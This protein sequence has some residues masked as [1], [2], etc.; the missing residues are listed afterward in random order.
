[1]D[2]RALLEAWRG[3]DAEAGRQLIT[4]YY[5]AIYRFFYGK[6]EAA[7]CEDLA[8][9][10]FEVVVRRRDAFR[11]DSPFRAYVYGIARFVLVAHIRRRQRHGKRF[12]PAEDSAIDP[13]TEGSVTA[14]FADR[15]LE[16]IVVQALRSLPLD[17]QILVEL[18]DWEG[19]TQ[20]E[21]AALFEA[22]QPTVARRLQRARTRLREAVERLVADPALRDASVHGLDS[23]MQ[24][25]YGKL[26]AHLGRVRAPEQ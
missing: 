14:L 5:A 12:E 20:A 11:G 22:P 10:T 18:K 7:A 1:M 3:G 15:E 19:L 8:Q 21:L 2:E 13:A 17:D 9:E 25:I 4:R 23:C 16:F 24:S 26:Q 6:A